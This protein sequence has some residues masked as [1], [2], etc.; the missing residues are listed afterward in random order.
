[1]Q[2]GGINLSL[3]KRLGVFIWWQGRGGLTLRKL[4]N[5]IRLLMRLEDTPDCVVIHIGG[6]T[7]VI[8]EYVI[9]IICWYVLCPG[10]HR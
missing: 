10:L 7:L 3:T 6:M 9:S 8:L 2:P 5:H 4:K 1:M